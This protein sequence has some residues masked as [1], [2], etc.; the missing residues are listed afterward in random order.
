MTAGRPHY[1]AA[2]AILITSGVPGWSASLEK[3][4]GSIAGYVR[5][6]GG[7]PQ[8]GA[9]VTLMNRYERVI[10]R[11]LTNDRGIFGFDSLPPDV[12]SIRVSVASFVPAV[13]HSISVQPGM[14]SLLYINLA[15]VLS[16][17]ELVYAAPGQGAI[18]SDEW[19]W[20]LKESPATRP[21]LRVLADGSV[22]TEKKE[23][24]RIFSD[25]RG[26]VSLSGGDGGS[27]A[28]IETQSDLGTA[29]ALATS[30]YGRN[31]VQL[32]GN[33]GYSVRDGSPTAGF[34]TTYS[35][36]GLGPEITLMMRQL[37][38]GNRGASM[39]PSGQAE[40]V[41]TLRMVS[42]A[43]ID[44]IQV[45]ENLR[46][47]YGG[48][49]DAISFVDHL[50]YFSPFARLIY[51]MGRYG[52]LQFAFSSG[53]PP[54]E[55]V[56]GQ[57]RETAG[58]REDLA[59]LAAMPR[60]SLFDG[61]TR[62]QRTETMEI[63][64]RKRMGSRTV[65]VSGYRDRVS[66]AAF[67]L[68]NAP[69]SFATAGNLLPDIGSSSTVFNTG[70]YERYGYSVSATQS[71]ADNV[72]IGASFGRAG[73]MQENGL[74]TSAADL[75]DSVKITDKYW[76]SARASATVPHVGTQ[77]ATS[78]QWV[79]SNAMMPAH[80]YMTQNSLP[81]PGLNIEIRQPIPSFCGMP[82][83]LEATAGLQNILAQGY[84]TVPSTDGRRLLLTQS[85]KAVRGGLAFTF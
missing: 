73:A 44:H 48:S 67:L 3:L 40:A 21:V 25:T 36:D 57:S 71:V 6:N 55:L 34:R 41:P 5:D 58:L 17:I 70:K 20:T 32:S 77:V 11:G 26:V 62:M 69:E 81:Q 33:V 37:A 51:E 68:S 35:R 31:Q 65:S 50:N 9:A 15:S 2:L 47:E 66:N 46:L 75:R 85:P 7:L 83:R 42:V 27:L 63:G 10:A 79:D 12:Y 23:H 64:Y 84:L 59:V 45:L 1:A 8:M 78:Y 49:L 72:E 52:D 39:L 22:R 13:K 60:I 16:S 43:T 14:Q 61:N 56:A 30:L 54:A 53:A 28:G 80:F 18:M 24:R 76:A 38:L 82:G 4:S 74:V 29:F 19:R